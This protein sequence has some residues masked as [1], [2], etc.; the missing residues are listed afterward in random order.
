MSLEKCVICNIETKYDTNDHI[1]SRDY[2]IEGL[3]QL[4]YTCHRQTKDNEFIIPISSTIIERFPNDY[5][6][7]EIIRNLY[8]KTRNIV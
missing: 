7:G 1:D 2:Y 3:G 5:D 4:C 6:L 8:W